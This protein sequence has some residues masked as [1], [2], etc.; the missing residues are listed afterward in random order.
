M[1]HKTSLRTA[2]KEYARINVVEEKRTRNHR[3]VG[4]CFILTYCQHSP[5]T[6]NVPCLGAVPF[7]VPSFS[8]PITCLAY[9]S[10][11]NLSDWSRWCLT[12]TGCVPFPVAVLTVHLA[13]NTVVMVVAFA[14]LG[15]VP[16]IWFCWRR[17]SRSCG[18]SSSSMNRNHLF[19]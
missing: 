11:R 3:W 8:T 17:G 6:A 9:P 18:G 4:Y 12:E 10:T 19:L 16:C 13:A 14:A 2:V 1:T 7:E 15:Q 5:N